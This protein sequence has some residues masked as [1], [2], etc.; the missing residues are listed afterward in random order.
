MNGKPVPTSL[1]LGRQPLSSMPTHSAAEARAL[2]QASLDE[3][4]MPSILLMEN[5]ARAVAEYALA[6]LAESPPPDQP[7]E[8]QSPE[9]DEAESAA[10]EVP[11]N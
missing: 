7:S 4:G 2:D 6:K 1:E 10:P 5:A 11:E 8:A 9:Q 3:L